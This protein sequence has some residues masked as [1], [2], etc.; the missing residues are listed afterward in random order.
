[1]KPSVYACCAALFVAAAALPAQAEEL[2]PYGSAG[3]TKT[4]Y[5]ATKLALHLGQGPENAKAQ[6]QQIVGIMKQFGASSG[7][8]ST[9]ELVV[10][11]GVVGAFAKENYEAFQAQIDPIADMVKNGSSGKKI[12]VAYCGNSMQNSGYKPEDMH[13]F[14]EVVPAALV[15]LARLDKM[16]YSYIFA[17]NVKAKDAR[18]V[19][20][21]DLKPATA[22]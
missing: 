4:K 22:K 8:G 11:G 12:K 5:K 7:K 20:R 9:L 14:G 17:H 15:E 13:G 3:L 2:A 10:Q 19:F 18:Y 1:M 16:G 21:P 6:L